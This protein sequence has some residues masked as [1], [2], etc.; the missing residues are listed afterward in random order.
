M[1]RFK[2]MCCMVFPKPVR[3]AA[4]KSCG[5]KTLQCLNRK[6]SLKKN[7]K[8]LLCFKATLQTL[9]VFP[10]PVRSVANELERWQDLAVFEKE[11]QTKKTLQGFPVLR[12]PVCKPYRFLNQWH[13]IAFPAATC[14]LMYGIPSPIPRRIR[15]M[16]IMQNI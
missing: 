9:Q 15:S 14:G 7:C 6:A 13:S 5:G 4:G 16:P 8:V 2:K 11:N 3:S 10:K 12:N 1:N